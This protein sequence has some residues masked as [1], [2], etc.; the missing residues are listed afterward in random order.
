MARRQAARHLQHARFVAGKLQLIG[1]VLDH[2]P[3]P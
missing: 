3:R 2:T 1:G